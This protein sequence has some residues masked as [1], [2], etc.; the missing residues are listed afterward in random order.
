MKNFIV[1]G[2][3][4]ASAAL[5]GCAQTKF[6]IRDNPDDAVATYNRA[7]HYF[8]GGIG[9]QKNIDPSEI[10]GGVDKVVRTETQI[11]FINGVANLITFGIWTPQQA[12]VYCRN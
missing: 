11:T 3:V 8:I 4:V 12:R 2:L 7:Q 1:I 9:Q 6:N 5:A 10:C